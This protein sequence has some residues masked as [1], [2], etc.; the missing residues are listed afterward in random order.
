[1]I[2]RKE[3]AMTLPTHHT[4]TPFAPTETGLKR[5]FASLWS[6]H[7]RWGTARLNRALAVE[8]SD[9]EIN[10]VGLNRAALNGNAPVTEVP[11]SVMV[12][13]MSMR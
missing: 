3:P 10:D 11:A 7:L 13:L 5:A 2:E 1:M 12:E 8:L 6:V 4:P 9:K